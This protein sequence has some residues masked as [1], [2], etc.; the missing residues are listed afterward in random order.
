[1]AILVADNKKVDDVEQA[2]ILKELLRY[3]QHDSSGVTSLSGMGKGWRDLCGEL[4]QGAAINRKAD[5][6]EQSVAGWQQLL[7]YL[8]IRLSVA[9]GKPVNV[10]LNRARAKDPVVNYEED[11]CGLL[12][13]SC[14]SAEF[15]IPNAASRL[16]FSADILRRTINLS[17]KLDA[18]KDKSLATASI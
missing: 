3:L 14:L 17:M 5:Y 12:K 13:D 1:M 18:P 6:V 15:D 9:I 7:R 11:V 2:Y 4:L 8:S 10:Y 16:A